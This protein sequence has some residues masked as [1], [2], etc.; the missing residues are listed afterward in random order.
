MSEAP[1]QAERH[2]TAGRGEFVAGHALGLVLVIALVGEVAQLH[3]QPGGFEGAE[4][5]EA[6][7]ELGVGGDEAG[8]GVF[9]A[10]G[11]P[12]RDAVLLGDRAQLRAPPEATFGRLAKP[13]GQ[14][15]RRHL[16]QRLVVL[17]VLAAQPGEARVG[18]E[19]ADRHAGAAL[20]AVDRDLVEVLGE[21]EGQAVLRMHGPGDTA[22]DV[23]V[24]ARIEGGKLVPQAGAAPLQA[25]FETGRHLRVEL[26]VADMEVAVAARRVLEA[27]SHVRRAVGAAEV[28]VGAQALAQ[29]LD[30]TERPRQVVVGVLQPGGLRHALAFSVTGDA[31]ETRPSDDP[32]IAETE[33]ILHEDARRLDLAL[34]E[35]I[36]A[37]VVVEGRRIVV[38][39]A[40]RIAAHAPEVGTHGQQVVGAEREQVLRLRAIGDEADVVTH[41]VA[42]LGRR[43]RADLAEHFLT[44][45]LG[46]Q[47]A[48]AQLRVHAKL[49]ELAALLG[50]MDGRGAERLGDSGAGARRSRIPHILVLMPLQVH[51]QGQVLAQL[52]LVLCQQRVGLVTG[53]ILAAVR[54]AVVVHV[55]PGHAQHQRAVRARARQQRGTG[56]AL[57]HAGEAR[58]DAPAHRLFGAEADI[59]RDQVDHPAH[60]AAAVQHRARPL[61]HLGALEQAEVEEGGDRALRLRRVHAHAVDHHHHAFL[62]E[63]AQHRVL[64]PG[65]VRLRRQAGL[66]AQQR[67]RD[68]AAGRRRLQDLDRLRGLQG[69]G[70]VALGG[71]G[72]GAEQGLGMD[73]AGNGEGGQAEDGHRER[74]QT[75]HDGKLQEVGFPGWLATAGMPEQEDQGA[76]LS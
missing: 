4:L 19:G 17:M 60:R 50:R 48:L 72:L 53:A 33:L 5:A 73:E 27:L 51:P 18:D 26:R 16:E 64:P 3:G 74:A 32:G 46:R 7:A 23:V 43:E 31:I 75:K 59:G 41:I 37:Q 21:L 69:V 58:A 67:A 61:D 25:E 55:T 8:G 49:V 29:R 62:L 66:A 11:E 54:A 22:G 70:G 9:G 30:R 47:R 76:I 71:D 28:G 56:D 10:V 6:P 57:V 39:V 40:L 36:V 2:A 42:L 12:G 13:Q 15:G 52:V 68:R 35:R 20:D 38:D 1:V 45:E 44:V 63:P 65:T 34:V 14:L 24:D